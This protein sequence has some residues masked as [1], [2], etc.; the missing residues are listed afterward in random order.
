MLFT[1][2]NKTWEERESEFTF[3]RADADWHY[4]LD[5]VRGF[6]QYW[7]GKRRKKAQM[8]FCRKVAEYNGR[9]LPED[10]DIEQLHM[11]QYWSDG[12]QKMDITYGMI[13]KYLTECE[14]DVW[15]DCLY[16]ALNERMY[17]YY[18]SFDFDDDEIF[19]T[20]VDSFNAYDTSGGHPD[21]F[22]TDDEGYSH[23]VI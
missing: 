19:N 17:R 10:F 9:T 22:C 15:D 13:I 23:Y 2:D 4:D 3:L 16:T 14:L 20:V 7:C 12:K 5:S 18:M 8:D 1:D 6:I 21:L 11:A